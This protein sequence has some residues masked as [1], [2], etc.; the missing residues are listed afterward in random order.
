MYQ[1]IQ[2]PS[3]GQK[4]TVNPDFTL[5]VPEQL[6]WVAGFLQR[7]VAVLLPRSRRTGCR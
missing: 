6:A 5:N 2:V 3:G 1:H 7:S 4:I